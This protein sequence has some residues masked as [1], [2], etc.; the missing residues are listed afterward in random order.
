MAFPCKHPTFVY[1]GKSYTEDEFRGELKKLDV[2]TASKYIAD[3]KSMPSMPFPKSWHEL[4]LK[5]ALHYAVT[6]GYDAISWDTGE[7]QADRYDLSKQIKEIEYIKRGDKYELGVTAINGDGVDL[8]QKSFT[9]DELENVVGKEVAQKIIDGEG[10][11]YRG[12]EGT[13]LEGLDLKVGGE[14]M[15]GFYDKILPAFANKY[16]KKWGAKV[17]DRQLDWDEGNEPLEMRTSILSDGTYEVEWGSN[18]RSFETEREANAFVKEM[19]DLAGEQPQVH[20]LDITPAMR[21][22]VMQGQPMFAVRQSDVQANERSFENAKK[23]DIEE[24]LPL[25]DMKDIEHTDEGILEVNDIPAYE[26]VR[27]T[28]ATAMNASPDFNGVFTDPDQVNAFV[29]TAERLAGQADAVGQDGQKFRDL[30]KMVKQ[31]AKTDGSVIFLLSK[32]ALPHEIVHKTFYFTRDPNKT[33]ENQ[34]PTDQLEAMAQTPIFKHIQR[35]LG[36]RSYKK[37]KLATQMEEAA[38]HIVR[39]EWDVLNIDTEEQTRDAARLALA[40]LKAFAKQNAREGKSENDILKILAKEIT[41]AEEVQKYIQLEGVQAEREAD[42]Q[43]AEDSNV[44]PARRGTGEPAVKERKTIT[45]AHQYGLI[46]KNELPDGTRY[47]LVKSKDP[48]KREAQDY[49]DRVGFDTAYTQAL[50]LGEAGNLRQHGSL[51]MAVIQI[52]DQQAQ[53]AANNGDNDLFDYYQEMQ[54]GVFKAIA[55]QGTDAG[56][57]I[58]QLSEWNI[59]NPHTIVNYVKMKRQQMGLNPTVDTDTQKE[60]ERLA[61]QIQQANATIAA[62]EAKVAQRSK[63]RKGTSTKVERQSALDIAK[64]EAK[65]DLE[66]LKQVP[67]FQNLTI[68]ELMESV[69]DDQINRLKNIGATILLENWKDEPMTPQEFARK[70]HDLFNGA[71]DPFIEQIHAESVKRM[72]GL[73]KAVQMQN[74]I[75]AL[76]AKNPTKSDAELW[77]M[78]KKDFDERKAENARKQKIRNEHR[79]LARQYFAPSKKRKTSE[80]RVTEYLDVINEIAPDVTPEIAI[81]AVIQ[82]FDDI[83]D[84]HGLVQELRRRF[85]EQFAP[86]P[87]D[88]TDQRKTKQ[89]AV[90]EVIARSRT[91]YKEANRRLAEIR[92]EEREASLTPE[93]RQMLADAKTARREGTKELDSTIIKATQRK[94]GILRTAAMIGRASKTALVQTAFTNVISAKAEQNANKRIVDTVDILLQRVFKNLQNEGL[95]GD[96]SLATTWWTP[97][98][99]A[100]ADEL[101]DMRLSKHDVLIRILDE[102]PEFFAKFFGDFSPDFHTGLKKSLDKVMIPMRIQEFYMRDSEAIK[103]LAQRA[104]A[105]GLDFEQIVKDGNY[106]VFTESD[107]EFA[108]RQALELTYALKAGKQKDGLT[109]KVFG[110]VVSVMH[111]SG[112]LDLL[113]SQTTPFLNFMYNTVN[114]YK[115]VI[116]LMAQARLAGKTA[117]LA[118]QLKEQGEPDYIVQAVREN[119]TSRQIANQMWGVAVMGIM[120]MAVR[121]LGDRDEWWAFR[122]PGTQMYLDIRTQPLL[123]P[124]AFIANKANRLVNGKNMFTYDNAGE[125]IAEAFLGT[126]YRQAVEWNSLFNT[127][128]HLGLGIYD[129][130]RGG[131]DPDRDWEKSWYFFKKWFGNEVGTLTNFAQLKTFK[132]LAAQVDTYEQ[133]KANLDSAPFW[134]GIDRRVPESRRIFEQLVGYEADRNFATEK[135]RIGTPLPALKVFGFNVRP[136]DSLHD[137]PSQEEM[138]ANAL[139]WKGSKYTA[140][141]L[142][143]EK[144]VADIKRDFRKEGEKVAKG[145]PEAFALQNKLKALEGEL[146]PSAMKYALRNL[147]TSDLEENFSNLSGKGRNSDAE[148]VYSIASEGNK[149]KL[150]TEF[151]KKLNNIIDDKKASAEEKRIARETKAKY[152]LN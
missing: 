151:R 152:G 44:R 76:K 124:F 15:R 7:T 45:S 58:S 81:A 131:Q 73:I 66:L 6:N 63:S 142:A 104:S 13:T 93:E 22:S 52:L 41:Y 62:Q 5:K 123:A 26:L 148:R 30:A 54:R 69:Q 61:A 47:Y 3:V 108:L 99:F 106:D 103:A 117:N 87:S 68:A 75:N 127:F 84:Q 2:A 27:R 24:L 28:L 145:T 29:N 56:Q 94:T 129:S 105:R 141:I 118:R 128:K 135:D 39:G 53:T 91:L 137:I 49:I 96:T 134:E 23:L 48:N 72:D 8:P 102:H 122:I 80:E 14:G 143:D 110:T 86:Q 146:K 46:N 116:P 136:S 88:T 25:V 150:K 144:R 140:P 32:E 107:M 4:A 98:K 85:P 130:A 70:I 36:W 34:I 51:Q 38:T 79:K 111:S 126:S 17:E 42:V 147:F 60:L 16:T 139:R 74:A 138:V 115:K 120:M 37:K 100:V 119:W 9:A 90:M 19:N 89:E 149:D 31:V 101:G 20:F 1:K 113:G 109:D 18:T 43:S 35:A 57:F 82:K 77:D 55:E 12:H 97:R 33:R 50:L 92:K 67:E 11:Q 10:K 114:K 21:D 65:K 132:D 121:A 59:T 40:Y 125:E 78:A 64:A 133:G 112:F 71:F 95:S 83:T